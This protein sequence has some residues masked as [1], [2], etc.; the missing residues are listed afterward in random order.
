LRRGGLHEDAARE[1]AH[2][3][4]TKLLAGGALEK[5]DRERGRFRSYLLGASKHFLADQRDHTMAAKRGGGVE[6]TTLESPTQASAPGLQLADAHV[7]SPDA[8]FDRQWAICLL[9]SALS[10]LGTELSAEGKSQLFELLK[11]SLTE[12]AAAAS[13]AITAE[14]LGTH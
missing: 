6:H 4:L 9:D 2:G 8:A 13:H 5:A 10:D 3:F 14:A 11:P 1:L 12:D 7:V